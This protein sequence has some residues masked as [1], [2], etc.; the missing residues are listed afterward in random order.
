[1]EI[2]PFHDQNL[3][4]QSRVIDSD[5][6]LQTVLQ[7]PSWKSS[8]SSTH[9]RLL[10]RL[11]SFVRRRRRTYR[12]S[13]SKATSRPPTAASTPSTTTTTTK[14]GK[15]H[16]FV[17]KLANIAFILCIIDCTVLPV[18]TFLLPIISSSPSS[19][20][21][22]EGIGNHNGGDDS[23]SW[24]YYLFQFM[25]YALHNQFMNLHPS[26]L[27]HWL[28]IWFVLPIGSI[29]AILNYYISHQQLWLLSIAVFGL[30]CVC[31]ANCDLHHH[32]QQIIMNHHHLINIVGCICLLGSNYIT[33]R[34]YGCC[35]DHNLHHQQQQVERSR[36]KNKS[37][38]SSRISNAVGDDGIMSCT[39]ATT[40][41]GSPLTKRHA[42]CYCHRV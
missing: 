23:S 26:N 22:G 21:T 14:T 16:Y 42:A 38:T 3:Q 20:G 36:V 33:R 2:L 13:T 41:N 12:E 31:I 5:R 39:A 34:F 29:S 27:G 35:I 30:A 18:V 1:M 17:Q 32:H 6:S 37:K 11:R 7:R 9:Q 15:L 28:A 8:S 24:L 10:Q 4:Q 19:G 25:H 40:P